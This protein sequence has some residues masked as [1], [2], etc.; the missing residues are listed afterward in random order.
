MRLLYSAILLLLSML[1]YAQENAV[2]SHVSSSLV[3]INPAA[4]ALDSVINLS[5]VVRDGVGINPQ[6]SIMA[7]VYSKLYRGGF[8]I[9]AYSVRKDSFEYNHYK[10]AYSQHGKWN[11]RL[12]YQ[13]GGGITLVQRQER[14]LNPVVTPPS[15]ENLFAPILAFGGMMMYDGFELGIAH[16][17]YLKPFAENEEKAL[18]TTHFHMGILRPI[19]EAF[20]FPY[21]M[22]SS[23][24]QAIKSWQLNLPIQYKWIK[25]GVAFESAGMAFMLGM[26]K[27]RLAL[28]FY[29]YDHKFSNNVASGIIQNEVHMSFSISS[30]KAIVKELRRNALF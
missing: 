14:N 7:D 8:G 19:G 11:H 17:E 3:H 29:R 4:T 25:A 2:F 10:L 22:L 30:S 15:L 5:V 27:G 23:N 26:Q 20:V 16:H 21:F 1:G 9:G 24:Q 28:S 13:L 6:R 18:G 12:L